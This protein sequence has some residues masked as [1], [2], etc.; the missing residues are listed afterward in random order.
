M[1]ANP[2][3]LALAILSLALFGATNAAA[4]PITVTNFSFEA[5]TCPGSPD[6]IDGAF[7]S[8]TIGVVPGWSS[9]G[10]GETGVYNPLGITFD[11]GF[12]S[13]GFQSAYGN[14][15]GSLT[16][17]G[18]ATIVDGVTYTL[19]IDVGRRLD[20]CCST[21]DFSVSLTADGAVVAIG[22][23][24]D[25][26]GGAPGAGDFGTLSLSFLGSAATSGQ[27][28][29]IELASF[30]NQTNWDNVRLSDS[31]VPEPASVILFALGLVGLGLSSRRR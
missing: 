5:V 16:Q 11:P 13:D 31:T 1:E 8:F 15:D 25:F 12:P 30:A 2:R 10:T 3:T 27:S 9:L 6:C 18:L 17:G 4:I 7:G 24:N 23:E 22:D 20:A 28:L 21:L 29:G 19:A 26:A 14:T